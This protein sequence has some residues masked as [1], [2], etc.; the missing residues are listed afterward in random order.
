MTK[1]E[2]QTFQLNWVEFDVGVMS[3]GAVL[4]ASSISP[5]WIGDYSTIEGPFL[6]PLTKTGIS[7]WVEQTKTFATYND[8]NDLIPGTIGDI[9]YYPYYDGPSQAD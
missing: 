7:N 8:P 5:F 4:P 3:A 2:Y 1:A 6:N 9:V